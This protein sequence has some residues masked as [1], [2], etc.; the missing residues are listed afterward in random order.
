M[1][2]NKEKIINENILKKLN[3]KNNNNIDNI[4]KDKQINDLL[5]I[6]KLNETIINTY[7]ECNNNHYFSI[8]ILII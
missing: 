4:V 7:N 8:N 3:N 2:Y 1:I 5:N 6:I